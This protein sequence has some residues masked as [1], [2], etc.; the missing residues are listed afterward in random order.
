MS[1]EF[2]TAELKD[3]RLIDTTISAKISDHGNKIIGSWKDN[4][5]YTG[6]FSLG[7]KR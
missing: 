3:F 6:I 7:K 1:V 4:L 5:G 2:Y